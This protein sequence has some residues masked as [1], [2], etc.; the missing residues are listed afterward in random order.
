MF[1][2]DVQGSDAEGLR[3]QV[4]LPKR[5]REV[6]PALELFCNNSPVIESGTAIITVAIFPEYS[7]TPRKSLHLNAFGRSVGG[8]FLKP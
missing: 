2:G 8:A 4:S 6:I 5:R 3:C 1:A 7:H